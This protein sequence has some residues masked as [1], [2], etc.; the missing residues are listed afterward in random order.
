MICPYCGEE[1]KEGV[2]RTSKGHIKW[3]E[4]PNTVDWFGIKAMDACCIA[5]DE[6]IFSSRIT[7]YYCPDCKKFIVDSELCGF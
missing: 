4:G 2:L 5:S 3:D 1:M 7:A 6:G